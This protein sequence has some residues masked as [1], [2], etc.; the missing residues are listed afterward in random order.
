MMPHQRT[1]TWKGAEVAY[2]VF[3]CASC[4]GRRRDIADPAVAQATIMKERPDWQAKG[5]RRAEFEKAQ[6]EV[7]ETFDFLDTKKKVRTLARKA[8]CKVFAPAVTVIARKLRQIEKRHLLMDERR[9]L[10]NRLERAT[11]PLE[12][13]ALLDEI[14]RIEQEVEKAS[15]PLAFAKITDPFERAR[16]L[17][18][19]QY[20]DTW[21]EC[22]TK[23]GKVV[24]GFVTFYVCRRDYGYED[25]DR[26]GYTFRSRCNS[27][28]VNKRWDLTNPDPLAAG[29][30][31]MC[32]RCGGRY[33]FGW[34]VIVQVM[35]ES[36]TY[37]LA[38]DA[39]PPDQEDVR[40]GLIEE[41]YGE[42]AESAEELYQLIPTVYPQEAP[43]FLRPAKPSDLQDSS[44]SAN[45]VYVLEDM[46]AL[47][48]LPRWPWHQIWS[49]ATGEE[50]AKEELEPPKPKTGKKKK[51]G[52]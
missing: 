46:P 28:I 12:M 34:G 20:S 10:V 50:W 27:L 19:A 16:W 32:P 49:F 25:Q 11:S 39:P 42:K 35:T 1:G 22:K 47:D 2:S 9:D 40:A 18:A 21:T 3:E 43:G 29:Q 8:L 17:L 41:K 31:W 33:R 5:A 36:K 48:A 6:N 4:F 51:G 23:A 14:E 44:S 30:R 24:A 15:A 52:R 13:T 45:G 37:F 26:N 7:Q 38:A